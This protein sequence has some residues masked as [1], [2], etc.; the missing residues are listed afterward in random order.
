MSADNWAKCPN[1]IAAADAKANEAAK[2]ARESYGKVP[3][4]EYQQ[5]I[6]AADKLAEKGFEDTLREDYAIGI[7]AAG[8]FEVIY[9]GRCTSCGFTHNFKH[10]ESALKKG[11]EP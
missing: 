9:S 3:V 8:L 10:S 1:C 6:D 5:M 4:E 11:G 7:T 2:K